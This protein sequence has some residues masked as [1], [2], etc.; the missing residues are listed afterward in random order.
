MSTC[1]EGNFSSCQTFRRRSG[2]D[3]G[4]MIVCPMTTIVGVILIGREVEVAVRNKW[5]VASSRGER[6]LLPWMRVG[7]CKKSNKFT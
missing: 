1:L 7:S 4:F 5:S 3:K 2:R 6:T